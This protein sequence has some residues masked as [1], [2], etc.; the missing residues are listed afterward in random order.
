MRE[1]RTATKPISAQLQQASDKRIKHQKQLERHEEQLRL[2]QLRVVNA[3]QHLELQ[4]KLAQQ[5]QAAI[6]ETRAKI[7]EAKK[8]EAAAGT[9]AEAEQVPDAAPRNLDDAPAVDLL[10]AVERK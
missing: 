5:E 6:E 8:A 4:E 3:R 7:E 2:Y 1:A 10:A 9:A